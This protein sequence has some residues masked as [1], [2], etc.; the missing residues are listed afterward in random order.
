MIDDWEN[1]HVRSRAERNVDRSKLAIIS[2]NRRSLGLLVLSACSAS[3]IVSSSALS[4]VTVVGCSCGVK[5]DIA[6]HSTKGMHQ[7]LSLRQVF[8]GS[9]KIVSALRACVRHGRERRGMSMDWHFR[10]TK[11]VS[12]LESRPIVICFHE[13]MPRCMSHHGTLGDC[14]RYYPV[15]S[16]ALY[17]RPMLNALG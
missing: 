10:N 9:T 14:L 5:E 2:Q 8:E 4:G 17:K 16:L 11:W 12:K 1:S 3:R 6:I 13:V 15:G 7:P